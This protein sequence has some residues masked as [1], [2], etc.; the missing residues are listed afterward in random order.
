MNTQY[1]TIQKGEKHS[2]MEEKQ[3]IVHGEESAKIYTNN[4]IT[5]KD[6]EEEA[7]LA[8][9]IEELKP[10]PNL[11][12]SHSSDSGC[13]TASFERGCY[14]TRR[15]STAARGK[16]K[17]EDLDHYQSINNNYNN[18]NGFEDCFG[19]LDPLPEV[20]RFNCSL[21]DYLSNDRT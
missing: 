3:R 15:Q 7:S 10:P 21:F 20:G 14:I 13:T 5:I 6:E 9:L 11:T 16:G 8:L 4:N 12:L 19:G 17:E 18:S 2:S 1:V